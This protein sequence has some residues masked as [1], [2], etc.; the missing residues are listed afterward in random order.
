MENGERMWKRNSGETRR[1]RRIGENI[2]DRYRERLEGEDEKRKQK[3]GN[4]WKIKQDGLQ[5]QNLQ[6]RFMDLFGQLK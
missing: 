1:E 4:Y 3:R 2:K 6:G 5:T